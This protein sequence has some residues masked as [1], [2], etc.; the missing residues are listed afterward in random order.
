M[1]TASVAASF[2]FK[3][4]RPSFSSPFTAFYVAICRLSYYGRRRFT[5]VISKYPTVGRCLGSLRR[6]TDSPHVNPI[7][8]T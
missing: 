8:R 2:R 6:P 3:S 5:G 7:L 4:K 1:L